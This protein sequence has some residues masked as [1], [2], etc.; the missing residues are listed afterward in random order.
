MPVHNVTQGDCLSSIADRYGFFWQTL[1]NHPENASLQ[2]QGRHP[3]TLQPGDRVFIPEKRM[4]S[5]VRPTGARHTF[6]VRGVPVKVRLQIKR[7]DV[8]VANQPYVLTVE[9]AAEVR[10]STDGAGW[11]EAVVPPSAQ[12]GVLV[13]GEG[14]RAQTFHLHLGHLDPVE[15]ER[16]VHARLRNLGY[17]VAEGE[18]AESE[19]MRAALS[20][21]QSAQGLAVTGQIDDATR[22]KL[23]E[24]HDGA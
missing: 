3:N 20:A 9:G 23:R 14:P 1:W 12:R 10:G 19:A 13:V 7:D 24:L 11:V 18:T 15:T 17:R 6:R 8:P 5:Y 16:G 4:R 22:S 2:E 21:F